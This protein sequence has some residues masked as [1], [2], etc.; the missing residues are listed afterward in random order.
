VIREAT[1]EGTVICPEVKRT[2]RP[3]WRYSPRLVPKARSIVAAGAVAVIVMRSGVT[4][5]TV[6]PSD[7]SHEVTAASEDAVGE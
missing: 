7:C 2:T 1:A 4:P 5:S 6:M 3:R